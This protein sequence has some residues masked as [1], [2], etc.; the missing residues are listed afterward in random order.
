LQE[1][2]KD[3]ITIVL[4]KPKI[5]KYI[6]EVLLFAMI[7][8]LVSSI[9]SLYRTSNMNIRDDICKDGVQIIYFWGTWCPVCK[10]TSPNIERISKSF[11]LLSIA[12]RSGDRRDVQAYMKKRAL[13]FS[14][15]N[16]KE[17]AIAKRNGI[18]V[19]PTTIFCKDK[20]VEMVEVGYISTFGLWVRALLFT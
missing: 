5:K 4:M 15:V 1:F 2:Y 19:F 8:L 14:L 9:V 11:D 12:V 7:F 3:C 16:D 17:G 18:N 6:K 20:K 10:I 13:S